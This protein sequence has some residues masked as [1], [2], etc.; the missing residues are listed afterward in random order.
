[1]GYDGKNMDV[2]EF[3]TLLAGLSS[4]AAS[5]GNSSENVRGTSADQWGIVLVLFTRCR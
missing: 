5:S 1:M 2:I 4:N 3:V